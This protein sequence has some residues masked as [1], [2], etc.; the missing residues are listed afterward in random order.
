VTPPARS[1]TLEVTHPLDPLTETELRATTAVLRRERG[2][3]PGWRIASMELVEPPKQLVRDFVPGAEI[4]RLA[5]VVLWRLDGGQVYVAVVSV[6]EDR[7]R[8]WT[9]TP[10]VQPNA[11]VDEWRECDAAMRAHP[12]VVEALAARGVTDLSLVLVDVWTFGAHLIDPEYADRRVGWCDV[13]RRDFATSNPYAHPVSGLKLIVDLNSMEL[14]KIEDAG[15]PSTLPGGFAPV[16]GEYAPDHIPGYRARQDRRPLEITQPE[17]A[18]GTSCAGSGGGCGWVSTTGR[19]W[20]CTASATRTR[21]LAALT[22]RTP[23]RRSGRWP[24]GCP[25]PR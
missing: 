15:V 2:F 17:R 19:A 1:G 6:T 9:P 16:Q 5:R 7:L 22:T 21:A 11:T 24:T 25:S 14:L 4:E 12:E 13:W 23:R 20:S 10:G 18:R 3:G 8:S